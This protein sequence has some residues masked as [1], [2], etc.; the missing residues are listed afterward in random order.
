MSGCEA[1]VHSMH[2]VLQSSISDG[3]ILVDACNA[4]NFLNRETALRNVCASLAKTLINTYWNDIHLFIAGDTPLSQEGNTQGDP[5]AKAICA[6]AIAP[7]IR[8]LEIMWTKGGDVIVN[9]SHTTVSAVSGNSSR[10]SVSLSLTPVTITDGGRIVVIVTITN[11][12]RIV[13]ISDAHILQGRR[14]RSGWSGF[15]R[16]SFFEDVGV[17]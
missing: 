10:Y 11:P 9:D 5:L 8:S 4:F 17:A 13:S 16:T 14:K 12:M 2:T 1:V 6:I 3:V 7:L 15:G